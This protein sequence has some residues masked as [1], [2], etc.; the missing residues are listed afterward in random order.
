MR[1]TSSLRSYRRWGIPLSAF[2][3]GTTSK[4]A[5]LFHTVPLMLNIKQAVNVKNVKRAGG[6][7]IYVSK[8]FRF[9]T[10]PKFKIKIDGCED[11]W[12]NIVDKNSVK[13]FTIGAM[14]RHPNADV[15]AIEAFSE[16][17]SNSLNNIS[18]QKRIFYLLGDLNITS[19]LVQKQG[20]LKHILII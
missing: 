12:L 2:S 18:K 13:K 14:Y 20:A 10:E 3:K 6:V 17:L 16:T 1:C 7:A 19:P 15:E 5:G 8:K 4:L 11:L 9:E